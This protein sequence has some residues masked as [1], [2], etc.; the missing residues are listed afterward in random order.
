MSSED[1]EFNSSVDDV[2]T[3]ED[4]QKIVAD[5]IKQNAD[6]DQ[7][8]LTA[9]PSSP[10]IHPDQNKKAMRECCTNNFLV[11]VI[12]NWRPSFKKMYNIFISYFLTEE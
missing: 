9:Y 7:E 1:I 3:E 8:D 2:I 10:T 11:F 6:E 12:I 4:C 5:A